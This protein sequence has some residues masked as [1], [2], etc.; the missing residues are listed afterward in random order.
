MINYF[1][2]WFFFLLIDLCG[3]EGTTFDNS[4][5]DPIYN[6]PVG[7]MI[8]T[9]ALATQSPVLFSDYI[10]EF[11]Q[12]IN[13]MV[14][15]DCHCNG[16]SCSDRCTIQGSTGASSVV[17]TGEPI[18]TITNSGI[19]VQAN[20]H[21]VFTADVS[22]TAGIKIFGWKQLCFHVPA[23]NGRATYTANFITTTAFDVSLRCV[24]V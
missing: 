20:F 21:G 8:L 7:T 22:Y 13:D 23:C 18:V 2:W 16:G 14:M 17:L 9:Q 12:E 4:V 10:D 1:H 24:C 15:P 5:V 19:Q 11:L 6:M 3:T